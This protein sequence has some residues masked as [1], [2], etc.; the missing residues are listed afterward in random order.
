VRINEELL[1]RKVAAPVKKTEINGCRGSAALTTRHPSLS[2]KVGTKFRRQVA[3]AVCIVRSRTKGHGFCLFLYLNKCVYPCWSLK[4]GSE[5]ASVDTAG[6]AVV[7]IA[8]GHVLSRVH[9]PG[10]V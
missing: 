4:L 1:E 5:S 3:V 8:Y 7:I 10:A 6:P 2:A 9:G